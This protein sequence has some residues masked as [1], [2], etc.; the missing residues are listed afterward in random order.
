MLCCSCGCQAGFPACSHARRI[1]QLQLSPN[2]ACTASTH[3]HLPA[4]PPGG[5]AGVQQIHGKHSWRALAASWQRQL[6]KCGAAHPQVVQSH[7]C[8][9]PSHHHQVF[10][11]ARSTQPGSPA[12]APPKHALLCA[13]AAASAAIGAWRVP[14]RRRRG[15]ALRPVQ[16]L[17]RPALLRAAQVEQLNGAI[18]AA[19]QYLLPAWKQLNGGDHIK[20]VPVWLSWGL[21]RVAPPAHRQAVCQLPAAKIQHIHPP[22][23]GTCTGAKGSG[24]VV[25]RSLVD[26]RSQAWQSG[27][28]R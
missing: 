3:L 2:P 17:C 28:A 18:H 10:V 1:W 19:R 15:A 26:S 16:L 24:V 22:I 27:N 7:R 5:Q 13:A 9:I 25:Y 6:S 21:P 4:V 8:C 23:H 12:A 14:R 20:L 11:A